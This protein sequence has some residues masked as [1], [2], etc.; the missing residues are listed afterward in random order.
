MTS[1]TDARLVDNCSLRFDNGARRL[2][3]LDL[4]FKTLSRSHRQS[5]STGE[6]LSAEN[7]GASAAL[8]ETLTT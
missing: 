2:D 4:E 5:C 8:K 6:L 7:K 3:E 1:A